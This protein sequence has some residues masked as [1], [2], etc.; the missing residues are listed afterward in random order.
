MEV[1]SEGEED[2]DKSSGPESE[3]SDGERDETSHRQ[4]TL[5]VSRPRDQ[6]KEVEGIGW[7]TF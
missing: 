6:T 2:Q 3:V 4:P 7:S 1:F 5:I